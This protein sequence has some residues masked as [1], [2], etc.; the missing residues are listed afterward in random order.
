MQAAA[1]HI[2]LLVE[3]GSSLHPMTSCLV[4]D[5]PVRVTDALLQ[6]LAGL[7]ETVSVVQLTLP[8]TYWA[9]KACLLASPCLI[10]VV[11]YWT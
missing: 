6:D 7:P 5:G 3:I 8:K 10:Q 2:S 11:R 4:R 9:Q 1:P